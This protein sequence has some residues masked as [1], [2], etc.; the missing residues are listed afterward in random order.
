M[1]DYARYVF[2][3]IWFHAFLKKIIPLHKHIKHSRSFFICFSKEKMW[4]GQ[5]SNIH[6]Q[7]KTAPKKNQ[8]KQTQTNQQTKPNQKQRSAC[9][10]TRSKSG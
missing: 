1:L 10:F 9:A 7:N 2:D 3:L 6:K 8:T 4:R 5:K